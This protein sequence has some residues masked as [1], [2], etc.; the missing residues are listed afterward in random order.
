MSTASKILILA[1][2]AALC[3]S[4]VLGFFFAKEREQAANANRY[5]VMAHVGGLMG[6]AMLLALTVAVGYSNLG[7]GLET[8]AAALLAGGSLALVT[9][10][11]INWREGVTDEFKQQPVLQTRIGI[12]AVVAMTVGLLVLTI[13]V[14]S[15]ALS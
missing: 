2:M 11:T 14:L 5:L 10:D 1:G 7:T 9:K 15:A 6:G 8:M 4:F 13:G 12:A 3:A